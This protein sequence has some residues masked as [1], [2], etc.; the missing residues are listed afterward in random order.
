MVSGV[1]DLRH[2][3]AKLRSRA[4]VSRNNPPVQ[5]VAEGFVRPGGCQVR[6]VPPE[7]DIE[8]VPRDPPVKTPEVPD[9]MSTTALL[10]R[11]LQRLY[12]PILDKQPDRLGRLMELLHRYLSAKR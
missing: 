2:V 10:G 7:T 1:A 9:R 5:Q 6:R 11:G 8:A 12:A 4:F 3:S